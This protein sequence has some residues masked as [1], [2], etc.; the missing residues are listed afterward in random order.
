MPI[1]VTGVFYD[2]GEP[3]ASPTLTSF[4]SA[5]SIYICMHRTYDLA[6][7]SIWR[8]DKMAA[9]CVAIVCDSNTH[10]GQLQTRRKWYEMKWTL[11]PLPQAMTQASAEGIA[12]T[13]LPPRSRIS[14]DPNRSSQQSTLVYNAHRNATQDTQKHN[15]FWAFWELFFAWLTQRKHVYMMAEV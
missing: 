13:S 8:M 2:W 5:A 3:W 15:H 12:P 11:Q 14:Q 9:L 4:A 10:H 6:Y 1:Y 7:V